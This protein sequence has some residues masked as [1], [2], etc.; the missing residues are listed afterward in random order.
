MRATGIEPL[1]DLEAEPK[2]VTASEIG[3]PEGS[4]VRFQLHG[5]RVDVYLPAESEPD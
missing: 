5:P 1:V 4:F 2:G 3:P